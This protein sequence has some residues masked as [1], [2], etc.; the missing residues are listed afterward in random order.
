MYDTYHT[1]DIFTI[2]KQFQNRKNSI[3]KYFHHL[4]NIL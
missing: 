3:Q 4:K 2:S 1:T